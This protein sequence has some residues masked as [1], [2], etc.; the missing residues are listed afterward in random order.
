MNWTCQ[1]HRYVRS[2]EVFRILLVGA[3]LMALVFLVTGCTN[4][5]NATKSDIDLATKL[6]EPNG[7]LKEMDVAWTSSRAN[8][9]TATC[10]NDVTVIKI[11]KGKE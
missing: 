8:R 9:V 11:N 2:R 7:G 1:C 3:V 4:A 6:C 10:V 5:T